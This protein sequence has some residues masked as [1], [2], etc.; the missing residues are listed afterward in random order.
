MSGRYLSA[1]F[2]MLAVVWLVW[3]PAAG[4]Q[5]ENSSVVPRTS[6]GQPDLQGV[7][8]LHTITPLER[9]ERFADRV[10]LTDEEVATLENAQ[11]TTEGRDERVGVGTD[12]DVEGAYNEFWWDRATNVVET[13]RTSLIVDPPNGRIPALTP[14]AQKRAVGEMNRRPLRATGGFESGRGADSWEDRS[15]W[16]RCITQGLPR[17]SAIAYNPNVQIFQTPDH[18][19]ILHE[20]IH[21][22]R[23]IP[24]GRSHLEE[25][26][27]QWMGDSRGHW[28]GDTLVVDTTNFSETTNFR[29]STEGLHMIERLT[30]LDEDTLTYD[31]TFDDLKTWTRTW[32]V[33]RPLQRAQGPI[34]E[35]ACHE[36]NY[37]LAGILAGGRAQEEAAAAAAQTSPKLEKL[38]YAAGR[39]GARAHSRTTRSQVP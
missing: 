25:G 29:G 8:S 10:F 12:Q 2:T 39:R 38:S 21:E 26:V 13:K 31:I 23:I 1:F 17:V 22:N 34:Y 32:T 5:A 18:V 15:L 27:R 30:R 24:I 16:E 11:Q 20:M 33:S 14:E 28:E 4:Q 7:W 9:P 3:V 19:V 37:S 36:G 6:W 35:Y